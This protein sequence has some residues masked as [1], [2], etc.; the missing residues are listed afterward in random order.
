MEF[1][2]LDRWD[3]VYNQNYNEYSLTNNKYQ[4]SKIDDICFINPNV[5]LKH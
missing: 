2:N 3:V 5:D 1:K 4:L